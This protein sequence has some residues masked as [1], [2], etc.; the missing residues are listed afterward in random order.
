MRDGLVKRGATWSY[1][2]R[3][4]DPV[5][6]R[7]KPRWTGGFATKAEA[8]DARDRARARIADGAHVEP[9]RL[10]VGRFM[11]DLWL[12]AMEA[13]G[14]RATTLAS[15]RGL[16]RNHVVPRVGGLRLQAL[17]G[18]VLNRLYAELLADGAVDHEGGLSPASVRRVHAVLR[19]GLA[20]AVRW[21]LVVRNAADEADPPKQ[22]GA[23]E[24]RH[25]TWTA[26]ELGQFL[27]ATAE[28]RH[29][30]LWRLLAST[31][32][33]R[34][35]ALGLRWCDV[36]LEA[37]R[38]A[39][40]QT[41][42][43]VNYQVQLST[44]KTARGRRSVALDAATVQALRS[45][46]AAQAGERVALGLGA[47]PD[48]ALVFTREDG[49]LI[50]PGRITKRFAELVAHIGLR[51]IRLHDL[52]HTHAT[53]GLAAGINPKKMSE[54]LG[55]STVAFTLDVYTAAVPELDHDVAETI[56]GLVSGGS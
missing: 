1:V 5:T 26:D 15:Y 16:V 32:M 48:D 53:L 11:V 19:K 36:D 17:R 30:P 7:T 28:D 50:H 51:P 18:D 24:R 52:R 49:A 46:K 42:V 23:G 31:G 20:D 35:E 40:R 25:Q 38:A 4:P 56:A 3:V 34:G 44:P 10:T 13:T 29:A 6:G 54:R 2:I 9:S 37:G 55:H 41:L 8:K 45:W 22:G 39:I 14:L 21:G 27:T 47:R 43:T 12:P 33:R